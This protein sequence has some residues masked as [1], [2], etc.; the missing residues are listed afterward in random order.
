MLKTYV[1][2]FA[3]FEEVIIEVGGHADRHEGGPNKS[4][5]AWLRAQAVIDWL[6]NNGV[7]KKQLIAN[8]YAASKPLSRSSLSTVSDLNPRVE[9]KV[10]NAVSCNR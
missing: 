8:D 5:L 2:E 7:N 1:S 9:F 10:V 4:R 3:A 6:V